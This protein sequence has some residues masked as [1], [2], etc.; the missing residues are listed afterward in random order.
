MTEDESIVL[1]KREPFSDAVLPQNADELAK[2]MD[3]PLMAIAEAITGALAVGPKAWTVMTGHIVQGILKGKLYQ[4]VALGIKELRAKGKIHDDF[5]DEKKHK[6][7]YRSWVDLHKT[8]DDDTPDA[9]RLEALM[10]MFYGA[11]KVNATDEEKILSYRLF[12]IAKRLNSGELL[13]LRTLF[14]AQKQG[15]YKNT[16]IKLYE[17]AQKIAKLQ[18]HNLTA[19]VLKDERALV[20]EGLISAYR[21]ATVTAVNQQV[22][23]DNARLTDLG[24][25]F[26]KNIETY[27]VETR[28]DPA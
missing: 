25:T 18:G 24:M 9:D 5:E 19:L 10:A 2:F 7:G 14:D 28:P 16:P 22:D 1:T 17:W 20:E 23:E 15:N 8:I 3:Q 27:R 13:L 4:Q 6:Y 21:D 26:C 12:Q 11:N